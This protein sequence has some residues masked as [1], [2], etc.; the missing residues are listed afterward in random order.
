MTERVMDINVMTSYLSS[1]LRT[2]KVKVRET[3]HVVTIIPIEEEE[4]KFACPFLGIASDSNLT[5]EKFLE[6]KQEDREY[7]SKLYT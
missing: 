6:M 2:K 3:G 7:E 1:I 5:V 4:K